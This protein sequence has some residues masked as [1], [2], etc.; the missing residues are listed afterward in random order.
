[1][2]EIKK[3]DKE[4]FLVVKDSKYSQQYKMNRTCTMVTEPSSRER[5]SP[6]GKLSKTMMTETGNR[7][8]SF[9]NKT[10]RT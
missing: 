6:S 3:V 1:V 5:G 10:S 2:R 7:K 8:I 9:I 4:L